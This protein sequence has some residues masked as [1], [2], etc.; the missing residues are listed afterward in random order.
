MEVWCEGDKLQDFT[1]CNLGYGGKATTLLEACTEIASRNPH[2]AEHFN[3]TQMSYKGC[4][5]Y[6]NEADARVYNG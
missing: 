2:F 1:A 3:K 4:L 6:D 5:L